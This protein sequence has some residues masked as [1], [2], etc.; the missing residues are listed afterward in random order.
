MTTITYLVGKTVESRQRLLAEK[1]AAAGDIP[2]L[3]LVPSMGRVMELETDPEFWLMKRADTVTGLIN[4]I[5]EENIRQEKYRNQTLIDQSLRSM[6]VRKVLEKRAK[7]SE[8]LLY[9]NR[10]IPDEDRGAFFPGIYNSI[11]SFFSQLIRNNYEDSFAHDLAGRM[12]RQEYKIPGSGEERYAMESDLIWLLGDFEELKKEINCY[13]E[14]DVFAGVRDFLREG[15]RPFPVGDINV[16]ILDG[17]DFFTRIEEEILFHLI[18][19]TDEVWWLIDYDGQAKD[20]I[21]DFKALAGRNKGA[22]YDKGDYKIGGGE[23][24]RACYSI[25]ALMDRLEKA[26]IDHRME[27]SD[28]VAYSNSQFIPSNL[29]IGSFPNEIDEVRAMASEIKRIIHD[30]KLDVSADLGKIRVV[31]PELNDYS[32]LIN[33]VFTEYGLPFSV[34]R[35]IPLSSHPISDIFLQILNLPIN[36]FE[37]EDI[38]KLFS[39]DLMMM[40][41]TL[42]SLP[43]NMEGLESGYALLPGD[44][45]AQV[46]E[47]VEESDKEDH[48]SKLDVYLFDRAA[49]R[50]GIN[51]FGYDLAVMKWE[52]LSSVRDYYAIRIN[53]TRDPNEKTGLRKEYY[54]FIKQCGLFKS[55]LNPFRSLANQ[56]DPLEIV[57]ICT[58]IL[59]D[60]GF[61]GN[62][63][64]PHA[65]ETGMTPREYRKTRKRDIRA[66]SLL[67][68]LISASGKELLIVKRL[69]NVRDGNELLLAFHSLFLGRLNNSYLLDERNPNVIR[70]SQWLE[71]RGRAFDYIFAGGLTADRFPLA[72]N[73]DFIL[74]NT[75][76]RILR[77]PDTVDQSKYLF[78][79]ILKNCRKGLY[80]SYPMYRNE[81]EIQPSQMILDLKARMEGKGSRPDD[82]TSVKWEENSF[83][84]SPVDLLNANYNK[85]DKPGEKDNRLF[86]LSNIILKDRENEETVIRGVRAMACRG[87][88]DGLFEYDGIV[89]DAS[90][91]G[92]F[93]KE[94]SNLFSASQMDTLAN[95]PMRYL[96]SRVYGLKDIDEIGPDASPLVVGDY[97]HDIL[98]IFFNELTKKGVNVSAIGLMEAFS[99]ARETADNYLSKNSYIERFEFS[100]F[101]KNLFLAGLDQE[102]FIEK[103]GIFPMLLRFEDRAL[104]E[105]ITEGIE[106]GFGFKEE[107]RIILGKMILRGYIDRFDRDR[108]DP[109]RIYLYDYKTGRVDT[110]GGIKKGLSFQLPVYIR[111]L[112]SKDNN[113]RISAS[114]YSLKRD[115]LIDNPIVTTISDRCDGEGLDISGVRL[116]DE[117]ADQLCSLMEEG[118]FHHSVEGLECGYCEFRYACHEDLGR[119]EHLLKAGSGAGI[120][121]G[122]KNLEKWGRVDKF[123]K[124]WKKVREYMEKAFNLKTE[125]GRRNNFDKVM[126]F[127]NELENSRDS[128]PFDDDYI[129]ELMDEIGEF[130]KDYTRLCS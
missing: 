12:E 101:F 114:F 65:S 129:D 120:Y 41:K 61:P 109:D 122:A 125:S 119:M 45:S 94:R 99:R 48:N 87:A 85:T 79:H 52:S 93:L 44:D 25:V 58:E 92:D 96:F 34:T 111:A 95:C 127:R 63:L 69:F 104:G 42:D 35:G 55:I 89:G 68:D 53:K 113:S 60:L 74:R 28:S 115:M 51:N 50:C 54:G 18:P 5:F 117:Y 8:R 56:K 21:N 10:L 77:S 9:F 47:L 6:L 123:R 23:A 86:D 106:H 107:E 27:R 88:T 80:L 39:S 17:F 76:E 105:R 108:N 75:P 1:M 4:R 20:P 62:I 22:V 121:S 26:G 13:D 81:K 40:D 38:F 98:S 103:E 14:D 15:E 66:Y 110:S 43:M 116:F 78:N 19:Q 126:E 83:I 72:D 91:F 3:H 84:T 2:V 82:E 16:F 29:R 73:R 112:R 67:Y 11:S 70:V 49:R 7:T 30:Q 33:E 36:R 130:E 97:I 124:E 128:L 102:G 100:E 31:F 46:K 24:Y 71:T 32:G 37:R 57:K 118:R 64:C 59:N 90:K